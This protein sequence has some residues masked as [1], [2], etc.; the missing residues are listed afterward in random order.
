[1]TAEQLLE[2]PADGFDHGIIAGNVTGPLQQ[3]VKAQQL[4]VVCGAETGFLL[5]R[6]PDTVLAPDVAFVRQERIRTRTQSFLEAAPDLVV[7]VV[8]PYDT[9]VDVD[10]KVAA[11]LEFGARA[12]WVVN[13]KRRTVTVHCPQH[14]P[15]VLTVKDTLDGE[16]VVP[17]FRLPVAS[18][19]S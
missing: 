8:S 13:P 9:Y 17:G 7:E 16:D 1:V 19:F 18:I 5:S 14:T 6:A 10:E 11:W 3:Y 2:M 4:G 12:V 15:R